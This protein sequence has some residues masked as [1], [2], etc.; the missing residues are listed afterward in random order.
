MLQ[1]C[2]FA[3]LHCDGIAF[4]RSGVDHRPDIV[5][6]PGAAQP[7]RPRHHTYMRCQSSARCMQDLPVAGAMPLKAVKRQGGKKEGGKKKGGKKGDQDGPDPIDDDGGG[8]GGGYDCGGDVG[9]IGD[10]GGLCG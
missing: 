1:C 5:R 8:G 3:S 6:A 7:A 4:R 10:M 9:G 2:S